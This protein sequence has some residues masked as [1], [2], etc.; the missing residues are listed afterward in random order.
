MA[1]EI[2]DRLHAMEEEPARRDLEYLRGLGNAVV[3]GVEYAIEVVAAGEEAAVPLP[4][5]LL[6]QA[7]LAARQGIPLDLVIRRYV[8]GK[9]L[10]DDFLL[11]EASRIDSVDPTLLR[12]AAA[13]YQASFDRVLSAATEEYRQEERGR[14]TSRDA[15]LVERVR[16][17]LAG[18]RV[19]PSPLEYHI[20]NHHLG[21]IAL[22]AETRPLLYR[23]AKE[24]NCRA[25]LI[26]PEEDEVWG[27]IGSRKPVDRLAVHH[28]LG[29]NWP[30]SLQLGVGEPSRG[31]SGW[32]HTHEQARAA[33]SF[34][35][36][37]SKTSISWYRDIALIEC[38]SRDPLL[39]HSLR[40]MYLAPLTQAGNRGDAIRRTL[41]VYFK[42][43]R[44]RK[45]AAAALNV[46]RQ[47]VA[48]HLQAAE[49][50]LDQPLSGCADLLQAAL[51]LEELDISS[52]INK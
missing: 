4:V 45:S 24:V 3:S 47:T 2:L 21:L 13:S 32:R 26:S 37:S 10:L 12:S 17:L 34:T 31:R 6:T 44:N 5:P 11:E 39:R 42:T 22:S 40:D 9:T 30:E 46:S 19:D 8:A 41:R 36:L 1:G 20:H 50:Q 15:R 51:Q 52:P 27:W 35:Q 14:A 28:W 29:A 49:D 18:E 38:I 7:R 43:E 25:L 23:L 16:R 48:N 33:A